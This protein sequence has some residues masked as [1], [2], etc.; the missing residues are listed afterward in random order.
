MN[1]VPLIVFAA[2]FAV[3]GVLAASSVYVT[4]KNDAT[5]RAVGIQPAPAGQHR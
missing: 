2:V 5:M 4:E 3:I 1:R